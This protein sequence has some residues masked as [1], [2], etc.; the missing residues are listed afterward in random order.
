MS[1]GTPLGRTKIVDHGPDSQRYNIVIVGDGYTAAQMAQ[2]ASDVDSI[3]AGMRATPPFD[4]LWCGINVYRVDVTSTD[5][6]ADDPA[7]C[8]DG[9]T[10]S[11]ATP[12]T[13]FDASFCNN[14]AR[15]LLLADAT[16]TKAVAQA[17]VPAVHFTLC[18]V[19]S[20]IYGGGGGE[21]A[22]LS[23]APGAADIAI[24]EMGHTAFGPADEYEYY[25]GCGSGE[26]DRNNHPATEPSE[27][28]VTINTDP[29]T[30]KWSAQLTDA[31]DGLPTT[32]NADCSACDPQGNP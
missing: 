18:V 6:G 32:N 15:R 19:N 8:G 23:L 1:D 9:S 22:T 21:I 16:T 13:Y 31:T 28:N 10:G 2:Y 4:E 7:T 3:V 14:G 20:T 26:T 27:P 29:A 5:S 17:Q 24:H 25:F 11:G 12:R 30:I